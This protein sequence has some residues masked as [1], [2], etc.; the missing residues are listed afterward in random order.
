MSQ[1]RSP[2]GVMV[3]LE[4]K[5][6]RF[7]KPDGVPGLDATVDEWVAWLVSRGWDEVEA[8]AVARSPFA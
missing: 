1:P 5:D 2:A 3:W 7:E 4:L 6:G 8:R